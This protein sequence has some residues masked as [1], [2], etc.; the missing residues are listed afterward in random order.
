MLHKLH[1]E[2][3]TNK[4]QMIF[5]DFFVEIVKP[6]TPCISLCCKSIESLIVLS[7]LFLLWLVLK[8]EPI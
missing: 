5:L 3:I 4:F 6:G 8:I 1:Q 7:K 2:R